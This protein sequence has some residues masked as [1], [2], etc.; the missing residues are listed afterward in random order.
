MSIAPLETKCL[1]SCR[2]RPG[3]TG[4]GQYAEDPVVR[5]DRGRVA[6]GTA[7]GRL[8]TGR[9]LRALDHVRAPAETHLRDHVAGAHDDHLLAVAQ[10]LAHEVLLV[11]ERGEL[12]RHPAD[13]D[14]LE[15]G[16]G[17][18][19]AEL[20]D[21]PHH[22][23]A[24][25]SRRSSAG[26]SRP[27]PSAARARPC[28]GGAAARGRR[29]SPP[30]RRSRSPARRGG[31]PSAALVD[32]LLLGARAADVAVHRGSR[33]RAATARPASGS[34]KRDPRCD[35]HLVGTTS[36]EGARRQVVRVELADRPGRR[37]AGV[38]ERRLAGFGAALVQRGEVL[39]RH[40]HL[41]PDLQQAGA[42]RRRAAGSPRSCAGCG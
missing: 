30:L 8:G 25:W 9:A 31:S 24:A 39:Q 2:R 21:V 3:Q 4:L 40:V 6:E 13:G 36:T 27:P 1:S 29:P 32:H 20:A 35:A 28:P 38:H 42:R 34:A 37:V 10:V 15:H 11:V 18:Q 19:V 22:P 14:R 7:R 23:L 26:T 17:A 33:A 12:D 16:V 5:L 41:A